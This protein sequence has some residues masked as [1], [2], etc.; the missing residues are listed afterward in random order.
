MD[1]ASAYTA[2]NFIKDS[3]KAVLDIRIEAAAKKRINEILE[4]IGPIQDTLFD[5]REELFRLQ[6]ENTQL[7]EKLKENEDW[8][9]KLAEYQLTETAGGAVVY[10]FKGELKHYICPSC[11]NKKEIHIL[12]DTRTMGGGFNCPGCN[13]LFRIK[14]TRYPDDPAPSW[15]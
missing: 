11:L 7:K 8:E 9:R 13:K 12:Q 10:Q 2:V 1:I 6:T 15:G 14:Q 5:L 4:K 3:L